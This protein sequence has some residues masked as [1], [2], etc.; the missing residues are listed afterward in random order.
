MSETIEM[1]V[2]VKAYPAISMKYGEVVCV[3]GTRTDTDSPQWCRLFP[4]PFRDMP[5]A[6]RFKKYA[7]IRLEAEVHTGDPRPE[8]YRPNA[9]SVEVLDFLDAKKGWERRK[10]YVEPLM[11]E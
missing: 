6:Q 4:V 8:S 7:R 11:V 9:D 10:P 5:F 1:V 3:A 2:T